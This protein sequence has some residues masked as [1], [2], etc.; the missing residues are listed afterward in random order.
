VNLRTRLLVVGAVFGALIGVAAA[1]LYL[2]S[3]PIQVNDEGEERLPSVSPGHALS[4][5]LGVLSVLKQIVGLG[6]AKRG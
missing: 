2:R 6:V 1:S 3:T 4:V 5:G